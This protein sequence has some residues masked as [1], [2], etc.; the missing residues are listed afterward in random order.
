MRLL[1]AC[2]AAAALVCAQERVDLETLAKIREEA[3]RRS[4]V[5][6]HLQVLTDRY[7]PRLTGSPNYEAAA[8]WAMKRLAGWGLQNARLEEWDF[9]HDGWSNERAVG[10]LTAPV[11]DH[12]VFEVMAWTPST[13][14]VA[15]GEAVLLAPPSSPSKQELD[16]WLAENAARVRGRI[17]LLGR[18]QQI[19][20]SFAAPQKRLDDEAVKRRLEARMGPPRPQPPRAEPGRLTPQQ[21]N[22]AIDPWLV[23]NGVLVKV[24]DAGMPHGMIRAFQNRAYDVTKAVPTVYLRNEDYGRAARLLESGEKVEM[25]FEIVNRTHPGRMTWNVLADIPGASRPDEVVLIGAHLDSWHAATGATDN[26]AGAAVMMEAVRILQA[27]GLRPARTIRIAL[28]SAEEQGLLGSKYHVQAH[29]GS[30][31]APKPAFSRLVAYLNL[32]SGTGRIRGASVF[33]PD[34]AAAVVAA[35][36]EPFRDAGVAGAAASSSRREGGTDSTSFS[37]AGLPAIGFFQD[38]IEYFQQTWHTNLDTYE[39]AVPED[40]Q[41]ASAVVAAVAWHLANR[42]EMLPR[43]SPEKMP[44]PATA[45][46]PVTQ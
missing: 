26:A 3:D 28:W 15:R 10:H 27:L 12:L 37:S 25:E 20:V 29:Y 34:E 33:G 22:A 11:R 32:D 18:P 46:P 36:L 13:N 24:L 17:V 43:F 7:G 44:P 14:G 31:E 45:A 5:M 21:V 30:Y 8:R 2:A 9:G 35:A 19:Q 1:V 16:A 4:E 6:K 39:R 23:A 40:L 41:Q 38:P 42:E